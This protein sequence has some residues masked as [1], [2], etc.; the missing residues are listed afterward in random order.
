MSRVMEHWEETLRQ[1]V[2][3]DED[4]RENAIFQIGLVLER[5]YQPNQDAP[6]LY[7]TNLSRELLRLVL[8]EK[9]QQDT[10][11]YLITL[12]KNQ[13][14]DA[15]SLIYAVRRSNPALF[16]QPFMT[17]LHEYGTQLSN[18]AAYEVVLALDSCIKSEDESVIAALRSSDLTPLLE[19]WADSKDTLLGGKTKRMMV[20]LNHLINPASS[21]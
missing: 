13:P 12:V 16:I 21:E 20:R 15:A 14:Q 9:R 7:E 11:L 18:D 8:D 2:A 4:D 10:I 6:D 5:H 17:L 3:K 1:A 19:T